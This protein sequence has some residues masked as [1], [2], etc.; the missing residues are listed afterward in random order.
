M[1]RRSLTDMRVS[2]KGFTLIEMTISLS[3]LVIVLVISMTLLFQMQDFAQRQ[4]QFAEPRQNARRAID[5]VGSYIRAATD[6][7]F[8]AGNPNALPMWAYLNKVATQ[9]S[10]NNVQNQNLG[11]VDTDILTV[12]YSTT[13][14]VFQ[15]WN[16]TGSTLQ[17][18]FKYG[19]GTTNNDAANLALFKQVTG[20]TACAAGLC[21]DPVIVVDG[22]THYWTYS[23]ITNYTSSACANGS[24]LNVVAVLTPGTSDIYQ[25]PISSV[26]A[27]PIAVTQSNSAMCA[28]ATYLVFRVQRSDLNNILTTQLQQKRGL[29]NP[30]TDNPGASF[31]DI[32]DNIEDMQVV[33]I[34]N[35]GTIKNDTVANR[36]ATAGNIPTQVANT[37]AVAATDI[38]RVLGIRLSMTARAN[39]PVSFMQRSKYFRP[40]SEDRPVAAAADSYYHY[41]LS[42]TIMVRSRTLG[43]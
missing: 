20:A 2:E 10:Y 24:G 7:N 32:L 18:A 5:Y 35:D 1:S 30:N 22:L 28:G 14:D 6:M 40:A 3:I 36:L 43:G 25:A 21:S 34:Y 26:P 42:S 38:S 16:I 17:G 11:E 33:Y 23:Q 15:L 39:T 13:G 19:C 37:G 27:T 41:R 31:I 4:R 12:G 8:S 29:F 9:M